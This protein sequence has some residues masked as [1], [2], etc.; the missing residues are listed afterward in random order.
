MDEN[1]NHK[2][3][4]CSTLYHHCDDC[5]KMKSFTP[6]RAICDTQEH[7]QAYLL[8]IELEHDSVSKSDAKEI[9]NRIGIGLNEIQNF[10]PV[11]KN[12]F[13]EILTDKQKRNTYKSK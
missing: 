1:L 13:E 7:Y 5:G 2:C 12:M 11:I 10:V 4:V 3:I 8:F 6:W 9:L